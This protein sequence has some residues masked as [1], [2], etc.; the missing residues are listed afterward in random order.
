MT[1]LYILLGILI[2]FASVLFLNV[3]M[4]FAYD[5]SIKARVRVLFISVDIL[6]LFNKPKKD[7]NK[8]QSPIQEQSDRKKTPKK[9]TFEDFMA[10]VELII[11]V[12]R[13]FCDNLSRSLSV[14]IRRFNVV[15][16]SDSPEKT[17]LRYAALSNAF[18]VLMDFLPNTVRKFKPEYKEIRIYP[19]YLAVESSFAA[20]FVFTMKVWHFVRILWGALRI[21]NQNTRK[22]IS[23]RN[24]TKA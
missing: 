7:K 14:N 18:A 9:G 23:E 5:Q 21:F 3:H 19:D 1:V 17:A 6:K 15:V 22:R 8:K 11:S 20:E 4:I 13:M 24:R 16:A 10:F 12:V 2:F